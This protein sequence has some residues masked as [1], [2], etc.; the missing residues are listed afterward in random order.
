MGWNR[1]GWKRRGWKRRG[2]KR[3]LEGRTLFGAEFGDCAG[4]DGRW[5]ELKVRWS[6][7]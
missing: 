6:G 7:H 1:M 5:G 4:D 2:W 3:T